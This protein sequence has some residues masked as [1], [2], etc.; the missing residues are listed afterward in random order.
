MSTAST[1]IAELED[2]IHSNAAEKRT[3]LLR[4]VSGIEAKARA[5]LSD[6]LAPF[7]NAPIKVVEALSTDDD[8]AVAGP[9]LTQSPRLA[10]G[11]LLEIINTKSQAHLLAI[12]KR[13]GLDSALTDAL[14]SRGDGEVVRTVAKNAGA[15]F[16][17][18]GFDM[19]V[20]RSWADEFLAEAVGMRRDLPSHHLEKLIAAASCAVRS[21]LAHSSPHLASYIRDVTARIAEEAKQAAGGPRDYAAARS[22]VLPLSKANKLGENEVATFAKQGKFE[23]TAV[24]LATICNVPLDAVERGFGNRTGEPLLILAKA[25]NFSWD[26]TKCLLRLC[27]GGPMAAV[28]RDSANAQFNKLQVGTAQRVLRFYKVRQSTAAEH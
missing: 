14:V 10:D 22:V 2:V 17:E 19:L 1:L 18:A 23:E 9:V 13:Q 15:E 4:R 3:T 28:D 8:I 7:A 26:T 24:A 20:G 5:E 11:N 21:R 12:S 27:A 16:S 6:R 25:A